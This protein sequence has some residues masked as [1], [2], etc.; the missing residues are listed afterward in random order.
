[1][2]QLTFTNL[3]SPE[4]NKL[5]VLSQAFSNT[6]SDHK[7]GFGF[8][9]EPDI[10]HK[11]KVTPT[12][13]LN[14]GSFI[15]EI[16]DK[17]VMSHV[18]KASFSGLKEIS[19]DKAHPF[20][21]NNL[22]LA[23][24]GTLELK[25]DSEYKKNVF[26]NKIDTEIFL[27]VLD[28]EYKKSD[29]M[30]NAIK[31][32]YLNFTGK[33]AFII[34]E[35]KTGDYYLVRGETAKLHYVDITKKGERIGFVVNTQKDSLVLGLIFFNNHALLKRINFD[36]VEDNIK[37]L[38]ESSIYKFNKETDELEKVGDIKEE[39]K[40][41]IV[42]A[43]AT[44]W[45]HGGKNSQNS[46]V[47][48]NNITFEN[49]VIRRL[50][51][52]CTVWDVSIRFMDELMFLTTGIP[53]LGCTEFDLNKFLDDVFPILV[54]NRGHSNMQ[55]EWKKIKNKDYAEIYVHQKAGIEFP[56]FLENDI[57][58]LRGYRKTDD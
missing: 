12:S 23:H 36:W 43:A 18:R 38:D 40:E 44:G 50:I 42:P 48:N 28:E 4:L 11:T 27:E 15:R 6:V 47:L 35:I 31:N 51:D 54:E 19:D 49:K 39:K 33:F 55:K 37:E 1:M 8:F 13:C 41:I 56:F 30:V 22:I 10:L 21:T 7:D 2:C 26:T 20:K 5:Y 24:N 46:Y 3:H 34:Y 53:I 57:S 16:S 29:T 25:P 9:T 14:I 45:V 32:A 52:V 58:K 17:P